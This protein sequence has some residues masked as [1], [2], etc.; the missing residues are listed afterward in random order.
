MNSAS[1]TSEEHRDLSRV[2]HSDLKKFLQQS[3][4]TDLASARNLGNLAISIGLDTLDMARIHEIALIALVLPSYS[5]MTSNRMMGRAGMFFAESITPIERTHRGA[6]EANAQLNQIVKSMSRRTLELAESM[7]GLKEEIIQRKAAEELLRMSE[8]NSVKLLEKSQQMQEELRHL[9]SQLLS[10]QE[11]ERRKISRE[12]HDIIAETLTGINLKLASLKSESVTNTNEVHEKISSTQRLVE[13][14]VEIVHRY[15]RELRPTVLDDLGLLPALQSYMKAF[16]K[17]TG[18]LV[19]LKVSAMVEKTSGKIRTALFRIIQ[20]ALMNVGRHANASH[21]EVYIQCLS[22][23]IRMQITDNGQGFAAAEKM[24]STTHNRLGL[25]GMRERV[26]MIGGTF[27]IEAAPGTPTTVRVL[28]PFATETM[29]VAHD[30]GYRV[31]SP[32]K[33]TGH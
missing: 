29:Y 12:L 16:T 32:L 10:A 9:S 14:S 11:E 27:S 1:N 28:I 19:H 3:S 4:D 21:A 24:N 7:T 15:A 31:Q 6:R 26:E 8:Q 33:K 30:E 18:V 25:L 20:E 5:S 2:Y 17:E 13:K 23:M 22:G